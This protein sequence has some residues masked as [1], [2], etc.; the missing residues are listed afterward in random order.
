MGGETK[1]KNGGLF[2]QALAWDAPTVG[3][4]CA[5]AAVV[6]GLTS[7]F[8]AVAISPWFSWTENAL[9]DLGHPSRASAPIFNLGLILAGALY[10]EFIFGLYRAV[11]HDLLTRAALVLLAVGALMLAGVGLFNESIRPLHGQVT[12]GYFFTYPPGI[13][14]FG[15]ATRRLNRLILPWALAMA[16]L[17]FVFGVLVYTPVFPSEAVPE[18]AAS[19]SLGAWTAVSGAW[20]IKGKYT[21]AAAPRPSA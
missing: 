14:V 13:I 7:V 3:G 10:L 1:S 5:I 20:L 2:G 19:L 4:L 18:L 6:I 21:Q 12:L 9:S 11:P 8:I 17:A 16:I 15:V